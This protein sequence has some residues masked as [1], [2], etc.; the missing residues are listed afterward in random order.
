MTLMFSFQS[1]YNNTPV[2]KDS[3]KLRHRQNT[4]TLYG[5][6]SHIQDLPQTSLPHI[7]SLKQDAG[8]GSDSEDD[9][10]NKKEA[11]EHGSNNEVVLL[12]HQAGVTA[13]TLFGGCVVTGSSDSEM[14][15]WRIHSRQTVPLART[16][17]GG[18]SG[19]TSCTDMSIVI[20]V[21]WDRTV[22]VW[23]P[24]NWVCR[25]TASTP[26][27]IP[28]CVLTHNQP[29]AGGLGEDK[30]KSS[31]SALPNSQPT[32]A[33]STPSSSNTSHSFVYVGFRTGHLGVWSL[34]GLEPKIS[35]RP[36]TNGISCLCVHSIDNSSYLIS[37]SLDCTVQI[38]RF[39]DPQTIFATLAHSAPVTS[40]CVTASSRYIVCGLGNGSVVV[41]CGRTFEAIQ[42]FSVREGSAVNSLAGLGKKEFVCSCG[43]GS[44][45]VWWTRQKK[46]QQMCVL[47]RSHPATSLL[48]LEKAKKAEKENYLVVSCSL[49]KSVR[50]W[51]VRCHK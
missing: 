5:T 17:T 44:L 39:S 32:P 40:C 14:R 16:H 50:I 1:F 10:A 36:H 7:T 51:R 42:E 4:D 38:R 3:I 35:F 23:D 47:S 22:R 31:T 48:V 26:F 2:T 15:I 41:W 43:D 20:S 19:L 25:A 13:L 37:G 28:A 12:G 6:F 24:S 29:L 8:A 11:W 45:L 18:I 46:W 34:P 33:A 27:G 30:A 9:S 21:A 49:D